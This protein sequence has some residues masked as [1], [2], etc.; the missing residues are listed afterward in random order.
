VANYG[1]FVQD[2]WT[3]TRRLTVDLGVRYDCAH[4]PAGLNLDT[5]ISARV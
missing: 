3:A 1:A 2:H 5:N 4:L